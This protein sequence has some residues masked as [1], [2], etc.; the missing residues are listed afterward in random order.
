MKK[1]FHVLLNKDGSLTMIS[2]RNPDFDIYAQREGVCDLFQGTKRECLI[3]VEQ[4]R[5]ENIIPDESFIF[6]EVK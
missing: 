1:Y 2:V 4:Y 3:F 6:H 5:D